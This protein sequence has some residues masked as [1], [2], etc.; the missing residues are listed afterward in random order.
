MRAA[1]PT[2]PAA[3]ELAAKAAAVCRMGSLMLTA[4][5][6]SYRVKAAMGRVGRA[7]G[8]DRLDVQVSLN[9]LVVTAGIGSAFRTQVIEVPV[10]AIN[11]NRLNQL[12]RV[13]LVTESGATAG[14]VNAQLDEVER[15][16]PL[17][18][19]WLVIVAAI[20]GCA[21]FALLNNGR[22]QECLGAGL[23]AGLGKIVQV[24]L[25][26]RRVNHLVV[27]FTAAL[28]ACAF[29]M[30]AATVLAAAL[31]GVDEPLRQTAFTSALFFLVPGFPLVTAALDLARFDFVSGISRLMYCVLITL[32]AALGAWVI[33]FAFG[34]TPVATP[35]LAVPT[36]WLLVLHLVA[37]FVGV[38]SFAITF[39]T[40]LRAALVTAVIGMI[41][42]TARLSA[43]HF[44]LNTVLATVAASTIIGL[45]AGWAS[46]RLP[47]PRIILSVPAVLIMVPGASTYRALLAVIN[48][49]PTIALSNGMTAV[50][51][52]VALTGGLAVARMLTDPA[53][54]KANP[55]WTGMPRTRAQ[56]L[57]RRRARRS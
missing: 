14:L 3:V 50:S 47:C 37:S 22:W 16:R 25:S 8:L 43:M 48:D 44:G 52:V 17:Y 2:D 4:G 12:M 29:Y 28:V 33:A 36:G 51:I 5:T 23:A 45:A 6:G 27:V 24:L 19:P 7:L 54:T 34:M 39:Q 1:P 20:A 21:G 18:V 41:A 56:D 40:P 38:F 35:A 42:N 26:R 11:A 55:T 10:P 46:Q 49:N 32:A 57:L 31:P 53:W 30:A 9:E 15:R 13:S